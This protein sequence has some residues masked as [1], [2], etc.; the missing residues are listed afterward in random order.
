MA[1]I[2][3]WH[4]VLTSRQLKKQPVG[5]KL[6]GRELVVFRAGAGQIGVLNDCCVHR[7]MRLSNGSVDAGRLRC[8]YHGWTYNCDGEGESPATPKMYARTEAFDARE[9]FGLIWVKPR[10][11]EPEFPRIDVDGY[12][13][14]CTLAHRAQAP[15]ETALDNFCEIEH[16]PPFTPCSATNCSGCTKSRSA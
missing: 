1:E 5:I 16:T 12:Y 10:G 13:H 11:V 2:D 15:L 6:A 3:H 4:P 14:V 9:A 7:R 8:K